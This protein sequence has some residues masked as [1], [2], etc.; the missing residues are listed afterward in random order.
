MSSTKN[1]YLT[2]IHWLF[3]FGNYKIKMLLKKKEHLNLNYKIV[4]N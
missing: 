3:L 4:H 2:V 1:N